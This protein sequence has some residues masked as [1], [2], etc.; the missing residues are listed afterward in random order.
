M[1]I[2]AMERRMAEQNI[3]LDD[4]NE[5]MQEPYMKGMIYYKGWGSLPEDMKKKKAFDSFKLAKE[6]NSVFMLAIC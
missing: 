2:L 4:R 3:P 6:S 5:Y 1:A